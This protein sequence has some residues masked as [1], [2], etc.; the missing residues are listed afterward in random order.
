[1]IEKLNKFDC[2]KINNFYSS[3]H[4]AEGIKRQPTEWEEIFA[5]HI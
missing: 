1:M 4:T 2:I 3:K 5:M